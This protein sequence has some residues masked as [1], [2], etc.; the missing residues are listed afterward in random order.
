MVSLG[1]MITLQSVADYGVLTKYKY[2][3]ANLGLRTL[4]VRMPKQFVVV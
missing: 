3:S 2:R 4:T 1:L